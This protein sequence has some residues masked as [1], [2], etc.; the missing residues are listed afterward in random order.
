MTWL[1]STRET[2]MCVFEWGRV[3]GVLLSWGILAQIAVGCAGGTHRDK[4]EVGCNPPSSTCAGEDTGECVEACVAATEGLPP[5][6][7]QCVAEHV[8]WK[9]AA[10]ECPVINP[11]SEV[12]GTPRVAHCVMC[13]ELGCDTATEAE[14]AAFQPACIDFLLPKT[15]H[16]CAQAC[17]PGE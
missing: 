8:A 13:G 17:V 12:A 15:T 11:G 9:I 2:S 16:E 10:C 5:L 4:C 3:H 6:C 7:A 1:C 14:C